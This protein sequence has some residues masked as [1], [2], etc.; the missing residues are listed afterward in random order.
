M[1]KSFKTVLLALAIM[2]SIGGA[3]ATAHANAPKPNDPTYNWTHYDRNGNPIG[4]VL[5][6]KT[7]SE[8]KTMLN[9]PGNNSICASAPGAPT[10]L[11]YN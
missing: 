5:A 11:F 6:G 8:A 1:K 9:C 2:V 3:F 7:V 4:P 10:A